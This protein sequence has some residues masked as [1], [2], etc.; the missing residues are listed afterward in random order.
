MSLH[1]F[2]QYPLHVRDQLQRARGRPTCLTDSFAFSR[3]L[4][5]ASELSKSAS[6]RGTTSDTG[7]EIDVAYPDDSLANVAPVRWSDMDFPPLG[8]T[9]RLLK[10]GSGVWNSR[11]P[12]SGRNR[13]VLPGLPPGDNIVQSNSLK[14]CI[15]DAFPE[16]HR[17][18]RDVLSR[19]SRRKRESRSRPGNGYPVHS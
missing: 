12:D 4:I 1:N 9:K 7:S 17:T 19:P 5:K 13:Y 3:P 8:N 11:Q 16:G 10:A 6:E 15:L 2:A 18:L 14:V